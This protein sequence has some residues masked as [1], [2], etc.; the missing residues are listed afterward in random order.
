[1]NCEWRLEHEGSGQPKRPP[2][3]FMLFCKDHRHD[4]LSKELGHSSSSLARRLADMWACLDID[5]KSKYQIKATAL[6]KEFKEKH[7]DYRYYK[8]RDAFIPKQPGNSVPLDIDSL[9]LPKEDLRYVFKVG[10]KQIMSE[11]NCTV[12]SAK[13]VEQHR[14]GIYSKPG[15]EPIKHLQLPGIRD[16]LG[17]YVGIEKAQSMLPIESL[18]H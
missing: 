12:F 6:Q 16:M 15:E 10:M 7:P 11:Q 9:E 1:M 4:V 17:S 5:E 13:I 3:A 8:N 18:L 2:N 14:K